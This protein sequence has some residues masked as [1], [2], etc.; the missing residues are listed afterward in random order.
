[1]GLV[2][3]IGAQS[4]V[5]VACDAPLFLPAQWTRAP[6]VHHPLL[7]L[8]GEPFLTPI[9]VDDAQLGPVL[10]NHP[11]LA[12]FETHHALTEHQGHFSLRM[13]WMHP[14]GMVRQPLALSSSQ[15]EP[16][17][18]MNFLV[19][20]TKNPALRIWLGVSSW[21]SSRGR[22]RCWLKLVESIQ[23]TST[24]GCLERDVIFLDDHVLGLFARGRLGVD[25]SSALGR[26]DERFAERL[27]LLRLQVQ[28]LPALA[29][30]G[31]LLSCPAPG[32]IG[33]LP[34]QTER[35]SGVTVELPLL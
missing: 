28:P 10:R 14:R 16:V 13:R 5:C 3:L 31:G 25:A 6:R 19:F 11:F 12:V 8:G 20:F 26:G 4:P 18:V 30:L 21:D 24:A 7:H 35:E 2:A 33:C 17:S 32:A 9:V 1:M 15:R 29:R 34:V 22:H 27:Q 23:S